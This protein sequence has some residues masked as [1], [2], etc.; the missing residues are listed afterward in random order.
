MN[1][2]LLGYIC[3]KKNLSIILTSKLVSMSVTPSDFTTKVQFHSQELRHEI[4]TRYMAHV[5][6]REAGSLPAV[7]LAR[8]LQH[9]NHFRRYGR[10]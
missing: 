10:V 1:E 3:Q 7:W 6:Q 8:K 2:Q 4:M 5:H 9:A